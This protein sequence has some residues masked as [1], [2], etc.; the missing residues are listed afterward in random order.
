[1]LYQTNTVPI[2]H[3]FI[4]EIKNDVI[5][6]KIRCNKKDDSVTKNQFEKYLYSF[7]ATLG[8]VFLNYNETTKILE[9]LVCKKLLSKKVKDTPRIKYAIEK[10]D[11]KLE[12]PNALSSSDIDFDFNIDFDSLDKTIRERLVLATLKL[13]EVG[14]KLNE[15]ERSEEAYELISEK[16][17]LHTYFSISVISEEENYYLIIHPQTKILTK[18]TIY[19]LL[20][21]G[22]EDKDEVIDN[23][24]EGKW[25][26]TTSRK[27]VRKPKIKVVDI[28]DKKEN[29]EE[30]KKAVE[31]INRHYKSENSCIRVD[32]GKFDE[33][34]FVLISENGYL[35]HSENALLYKGVVKEVQERLL[36]KDRYVK[37]LDKALELI[38]DCKEVSSSNPKRRRLFNGRITTY[39]KTI[40]DIKVKVRPANSNTLVL[41]DYGIVG[42]LFNWI[43]YDKEEIYLPYKIPEII[44]GETV[45]IYIFYD[46]Y[47][48]EKYIEELIKYISKLNKL[49]EYDENIPHFEIKGHIPVDYSNVN[50]V[51]ITMGETINR[52]SFPFIF[53]IAPYLKE[54]NFNSIK[55]FIYR[56]GWLCQAIMKENLLKHLFAK[57]KR[58]YLN[59]IFTQLFS[60]LGMYL[61]SIDAEF[62]E[63]YDF[64]IGYDIS[65]IRNK[66]GKY[67]GVGGSAIIYNQNGEIVNIISHNKPHSSSEI[68]EYRELMEK[69]YDECIINK[70]VSSTGKNRLIRIL[71]LKDGIIYDDELKILKEITKDMPFQITYMDVRKRIKLKL[72]REVGNKIYDPEKNAYTKFGDE[73]YIISHMYDRFIKTPI[74]VSEKYIISEGK[75]NKVEI[76]EDDI[77]DIILLSKLNYSQ[78]MPD[79]MKLPAP[80]HYSHKFVKSI[81]KGWELERN[82]DKFLSNGFLYFI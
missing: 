20:V 66:R 48:P 15:F 79:K 17:D 45:D 78:L 44:R 26:I 5:K 50:N 80:V 3:E 2:S 10:F 19:S 59:S 14:E 7:S 76:T 72:F 9:V 57:S 33:F 71:L 41:E 29:P 30:Y 53:F 39:V 12:I 47:L 56:N 74:K 68:A 38:K 37:Y 28:I 23:L 32:T 49:N 75:C 62:G 43:I 8:G 77:K 65:K 1:M 67:T 70:M 36:E 54:D 24:L 60:K 25:M 82:K 27:D 42:K 21:D 69:V 13:S 63:K 31:E 51:K 61:Y 11:K 58:Y 64:I 18:K 6:L 35:Y 4:N 52:N 22:E 81:L 40:K 34:K 55:K 16:Y 46:K 73:W